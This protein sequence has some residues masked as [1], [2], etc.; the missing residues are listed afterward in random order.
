MNLSNNFACNH[1]RPNGISFF[2]RDFRLLEMAIPVQATERCTQYTHLARIRT[3]NWSRACGSSCSSSHWRVLYVRCLQSIH[4]LARMPCFASCLT[5]TRLH[6]H[7][8]LLPHLLCCSLHT[9][10]PLPLRKLDSCL[11]DLPNSLRSHS[12]R[13]G[14]QSWFCQRCKSDSKLW[15][16]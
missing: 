4:Y 6:L 13:I 16:S 15:K 11:A 8:A 14:N 9:G 7:R 10:L 2:Y 3:R 1:F 5:R 12:E